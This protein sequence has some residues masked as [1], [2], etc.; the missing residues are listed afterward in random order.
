[1]LNIKIMINL[2]D[3]TMGKIF[4]AMYQ[5]FIDHDEEY[6]FYNNLIQENNCKTTLEIGS[7]TG[8]LS[9]HFQENKLNYIELDY[10]LSMIPFA[11]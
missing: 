8:N 11:K 5:T 9:K 7:G 2:Y 4:D 10:S 1:M 3:G 6:H